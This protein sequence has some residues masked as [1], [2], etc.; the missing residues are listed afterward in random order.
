V[1]IVVL[2]RGE[3]GAMQRWSRL[4]ISIAAA[5]SGASTLLGW[6]IIRYT[7]QHSPRFQQIP[8]YLD[9]QVVRLE[10]KEWYLLSPEVVLS[11]L[12]LWMTYYA[13]IWNRFALRG[14]KI[15]EAYASRNPSLGRINF[16][17]LFVAISCSICALCTLFVWII[18]YRAMIVL[19]IGVSP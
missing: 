3:V 18:V 7:Y 2:K 10:N 6:L 17:R 8:I 19:K 12:F 5:F 16:S 1:S 15:Q 13:L 11:F 9:G 4:P 14:R